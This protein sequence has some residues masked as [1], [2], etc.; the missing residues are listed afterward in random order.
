[1]IYLGLFGIIRIHLTTQNCFTYERRQPKAGE[2]NNHFLYRYSLS[3]V[4]NLSDTV[5]SPL[6]CL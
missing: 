4:I 3:R 2:A 1:M 5:R 6:S